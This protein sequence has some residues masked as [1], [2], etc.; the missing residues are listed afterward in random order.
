[1]LQHMKR[2]GGK[3]DKYI[4]MA[5]DKRRKFRLA[6]F[7]HRI[8]KTHDPLAVIIKQICHRM[9][10][11]EAA[12]SP[13]LELAL[14][15][16]ERALKD[17]YFVQRKL[18]PNVDFYSGLVYL[19]LGIPVNMFTVVFAIGRMPGWIAHWKE[20][21]NDPEGKIGRPRQIYVGKSERDYVPVEERG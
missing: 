13:L 17:E 21:V 7:G 18:Y 19:A 1:M 20:M 11:E 12:A 4:A 14:Q 16:E 6:G 5:K 2:R 8:Y 3:A 10:E 15:L 9:L